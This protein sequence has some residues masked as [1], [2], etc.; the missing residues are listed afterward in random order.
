MRTAIR[1]QNDS[2]ARFRAASKRTG[3]DCKG[4]KDVTRQEDK[5][6]TDINLILH[7]FGVDPQMMRPAEY[8]REI[9]YTLDLQQSL[10][11]IQQSRRAYNRMTP[12]IKSKYGNWE[13]FVAAMDSGELATELQKQAEKTPKDNQRPIPEPPVEKAPEPEKT[14]QKPKSGP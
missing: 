13:N 3:L 10:D 7:R 4:S 6:S 2:L 5:D 1:K 14:E 9:D 8:G 11:A 12:E